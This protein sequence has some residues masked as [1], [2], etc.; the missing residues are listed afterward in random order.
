MKSFSK[1]GALLFAAAMA[2]CAFVMPSMSSAAS[3]SPVGLETTLDSPDIGFTTTN[4]VLGSIVSSCTRSSFTAAVLN[5]Q[6][7]NIT[8]ATF[9]GHCVWVF[10]NVGGGGATCT[11]TTVATS[12][13]YRATATTTSNIQI[14]NL[15]LDV[16]FENT[17]GNG[18]CS[19]A[20]LA[21]ASFLITGTLGGGRW[22]GN[23][24][25]QRSIVYSNA[26]GLVSHGALGNN[27]PVTVRGLF[28]STGALQVS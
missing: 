15:R 20:G 28:A 8:A 21:G 1:K 19:D 13:P 2:L 22:T 17:P 5:A 23:A 16:L 4:P 12:L 7:L 3:W 25:G 10:A 14:H 26:E 18:R 9:G 27:I 11:A 6:S 24:V